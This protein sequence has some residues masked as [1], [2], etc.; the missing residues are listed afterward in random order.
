M[1]L[2]R[3]RAHADSGTF[4]RTVRRV[5]APGAAPATRGFAPMYGN[6]GA[7]GEK[8]VSDTDSASYDVNTTG[9]FTLLHCPTPGTDFTNRIGRKTQIKS[10]Y[11]RGFCSS[12]AEIT[13]LQTDQSGQLLRLIVFWDLQPNGAAPALLDVLKQAGS[14]SQLNLNNRDRFKI[15]KDKQF[16]LQAFS[17]DKTAG[18]GRASVQGQRYAIKW[19]KKF[20][21]KDS[22]E[23]IF[24]AG[25]AGTIADINSGAL[26]MLWVGNVAS[27]QADGRANVSVRVRFI[28]A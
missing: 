19:F 8:K 21:A 22:V 25:A 20:T 5:G 10:V 11:I 1:S 6:M 24:N 3:K 16:I 4:S 17:L 14:T 23:T 9:S 13:Q 12:E 18:M 26:Y 2:S 7:K 27:S 15:I 28:D